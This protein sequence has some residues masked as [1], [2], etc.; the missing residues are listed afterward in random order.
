MKADVGG[1]LKTYFHH[2][3]AKEETITSPEHTYGNHKDSVRFNDTP[4]LDPKL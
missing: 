1:V 4:L 3:N 2:M